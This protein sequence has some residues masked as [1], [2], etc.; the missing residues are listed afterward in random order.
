M[1]RLQD[2]VV[3]ITGTGGGQGRAASLLFA[4]EGARIVGCGRN[5]DN[6]AE[7]V[8][9]VQAAG[10]EM[11]S[12]APTDL[13]EESA[14]DELIAAAV[15][16]FGGVD[17]LYNN[18]G[19]PRFGAPGEMTTED[20]MFTLRHELDLVFFA[21]RAA[22]PHLIE[23]D[24]AAIVNVASIAGIVGVR[25]QPQTAHAATKMGVIGMTRQ[26]AAEGAG[27]G[28]RVNCV[29]PG[30]IDTPATSA[31]IGMGDDG[32][33]GEFIAGLPLGRAGRAEEVALA[34]LFLAS[35]EAS[36]I[37]GVN[38]VVDGGSSVLM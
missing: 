31:M 1:G 34:A 6:A 10:C 23:S 37:T 36:Y 30:L 22:W 35:D 26:L 24:G 3:V 17:V 5:A 8:E 27:H 25:N 28:I 13:T 33:L 21:T 11:I 18:A 20:W 15:E 19:E 9:M 7:T 4:R 29:S 12:V 2:K 32:P 38:L 16:E 14:A